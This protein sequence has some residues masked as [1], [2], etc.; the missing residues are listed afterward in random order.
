MIF[1]KWPLIFFEPLLLLI[2]FLLGVHHIVMHIVPISIWPSPQFLR[3][4]PLL[5]I[6][7]L[8]SHAPPVILCI[9][10]LWHHHMR[11]SV[12]RFGYIVIFLSNISIFCTWS[13]NLHM[14]IHPVVLIET[15]C[16]FTWRRGI[17]LNCIRDKTNW[18][19]RYYWKARTCITTL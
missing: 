19:K 3:Q 6:Q 8:V 13:V 16:K 15:F 7:I 17:K 12:H 5:V 18:W 1:I 2:D 10:L 11:F 4:F 14:I 9:L